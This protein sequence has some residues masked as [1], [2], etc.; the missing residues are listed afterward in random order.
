[1]AIVNGKFVPDNFAGSNQNQA[2]MQ[3]APA[4]PSFGAAQPSAQRQNQQTVNHGPQMGNVTPS[5]QMAAPLFANQNAMK[6]AQ[7]QYQQNKTM[8][9]Q[10][11][12]QLGAQR[13]GP[14]VGIPGRYNQAPGYQDPGFQG[15]QQAGQAYQGAQH[16][17][18]AMN[19][20]QMPYQQGQFGN[21]KSV[22]QSVQSGNPQ[23]VQ[24]FLTALKQAGAGTNNT[25][26]NAAGQQGQQA[27]GGFQGFGYN[28]QYAGPAAQMYSGP[29]G[30]QLG[31]A[32]NMAYGN[33]GSSSVK[34]YAQQGYGGQSGSINFGSQGMLN[35]T[36][37]PA[38]D[39][40][41]TLN[42]MPK[43]ANVAGY[44]A[45]LF[46]E[47]GEDGKPL[48]D[49]NVNNN[50]PYGLGSDGQPYA[51][52]GK[53]PNGIPNYIDPVS[54]EWNPVA[55]SDETAK[56]EIEP[57]QQELEDFL[58]S[59]G[60]Y[61]YEYKN[62]EYGEGRRISPMAQE[63]EKSPLGKIAISTNKEGYKQVDYG[64]LGG[65]MLAA[66]AMQNNKINEL[67]KQMKLS[68]AKNVS[69]KKKG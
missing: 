61:S 42:Q 64:K 49:P 65:T 18:P 8:Q 16:S 15:P 50:S 60:V 45:P 29:M 25:F 2:Q 48:F 20:Q 36:G 39:V 32:G 55:T 19:F 11:P 47:G 26:M 51:P 57:G 54:G 22:E 14:P 67:S 9:F 17:Q 37:N 53:G 52:Y 66:L 23:S 21:G 68:I 28:G 1:M 40:N 56:Q 31:Y 3:N 46:S 38:Y 33:T 13:Q 41:P 12:Q 30:G 34:N 27:Q 69:S 35:G 59:L 24:N 10:Q 5:N 4:A 58:G 62:K 63:I 6:I 44:N 7:P 43:T